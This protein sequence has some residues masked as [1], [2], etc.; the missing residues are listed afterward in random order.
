MILLHRSKRGPRV[1]LI[2]RAREPFKGLWALPG[3]FVDKDETLEKAA[4]REL[5]EETGLEGIEL[6]RSGGG[7]ILAGG[8]AA[9]AGGQS[10]RGGSEQDDA[11]GRTRPGGAD[12]D[13]DV[14]VGF[15]W[16]GCRGPSGEGRVEG[17]CLQKTDSSHAVAPGFP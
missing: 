14:H 11:E 5:F 2:R 12:R 3:G 9:A 16:A 17:E 10:E 15:L 8:R 6:K 4:A 1:L 13:A 7:D